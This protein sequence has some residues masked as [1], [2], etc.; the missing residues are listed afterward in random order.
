MISDSDARDL[1]NRY[2]RYEPHQ[3]SPRSLAAVFIGCDLG[4]T[5]DFSAVVVI[6][7]I[8]QSLLTGGAPD[9]PWATLGG[10]RAGRGE[11]L[12]QPVKL[13]VRHIERLL[14]RTPRLTIIGRIRALTPKRSAAARR[15]VPHYL[16]VDATGVRLSALEF[17][18]R[19]L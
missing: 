4:R 16:V 9:A 14:P 19:D 3:R 10:L 7:K 8:G 12:D 11:P 2:A 1:S 5:D 17:A 13:R 18:I 15:L 6:E